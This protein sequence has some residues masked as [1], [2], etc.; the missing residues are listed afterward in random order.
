MYLGSV[1]IISLSLSWNK[2]WSYNVVCSITSTNLRQ[3]LSF[4]VIPN[5][6]F[7]IFFS[8]KEVHFVIVDKKEFIYIYNITTTAT[9]YAVSRKVC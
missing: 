1:C 3:F 4:C 9:Q 7:V 6:F 8:L 2:S 5:N